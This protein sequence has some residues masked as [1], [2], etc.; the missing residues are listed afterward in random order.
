MSTVASLIA[1]QLASRQRRNPKYTLRSFARD[2][3]L[4]PGTLSAIMLGRRAIPKARLVDICDRMALAPRQRALFLKLWREEA[5]QL[6]SPVDDQ[7][8]SVEVDELHFQILS[9]W[10]HF[11][12]LSLL[13]TA[14]FRSDPGWIAGRLGISVPRVLDVLD[15]LQAAGFVS[16]S[17]GGELKRT[18]PP[19]KTSE[20]VASAA[21]RKAHAE[22]LVL[23]EKALQSVPVD[24][25]NFS[26]MTMAMNPERMAEAVALI[27]KFRTDL[28]ALCEEN[29]AT[30]V[31]Q[32]CI[33]I[34][35]L[36]TTDFGGAKD[37]H[38]H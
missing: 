20:G 35:P 25:R 14:G 21:L 32:I 1:R 15:R 19:L 27:T 31:Y 11:A 16:R 2:L 26:S 29:Q 7:T 30:E 23:A 5:V 3:N 18:T 8:E 28:A 4:N 17:S 10:E 12:F 38:T 34:F 22:E 24:R 33:Q 9:E 37:G 13:R 6:S 36:T